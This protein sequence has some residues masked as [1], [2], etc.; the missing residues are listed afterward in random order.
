MGTFKPDVMK[1]RWGTAKG[2]AEDLLHIKEAF[3]WGKM[4]LEEEKCIYIG[5][6]GVAG[7]TKC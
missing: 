2:K 4:Y 3:R 1:R 6:E 5:R 7:A